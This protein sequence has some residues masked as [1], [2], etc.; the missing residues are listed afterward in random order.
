[1]LAH[2]PY[3][4]LLL[5]EE[6]KCF[7]KVRW[8]GNVPVS[9]SASAFVLDIL[10]TLDHPMK[11]STST[12][13]T[14]L[15]T[16]SSHSPFHAFQKMPE[17]DC[18]SHTKSIK[19]Y[20][21]DDCEVHDIHKTWKK[22]RSCNNK[23]ELRQNFANRSEAL[24]SALR[25]RYSAL[26]GIDMIPALLQ[27][28]FSS[29]GKN[30]EWFEQNYEHCDRD[31]HLGFTGRVSGVVD[32]LDDTQLHE[33]LTRSNKHGGMSLQLQ[34]ERLLKRVLN[35]PIPPKHAPE[36]YNLEQGIRHV[37]FGS[38]QQPLLDAAMISLLTTKNKLT[39]EELD[40]FMGMKRPGQHCRLLFT[41][42]AKQGTS[43]GVA[44]ENELKTIFAG[45][46]EGS[47]MLGKLVE[48]AVQVDT[49]ECVRVNALLALLPQLSL[50]SPAQAKWF[51]YA[52]M[53]FENQYHENLERND[54]TYLSAQLPTVIV[55]ALISLFHEGD[56]IDNNDMPGNNVRIAAAIRLGDAAQECSDSRVLVL[57]AFNRALTT[58]SEKF[59]T[60]IAAFEENWRLLF[61]EYMLRTE[62][63]T[64]LDVICDMQADGCIKEVRRM[65]QRTQGGRVV[66][67]SF[68]RFSSPEKL[69]VMDF[70]M[71]MGVK[72]ARKKDQRAS[73]G[74]M[75]I[76]LESNN[77]EEFAN[78]MKQLSNE[79][80]NE[81]SMEQ[82]QA[83]LQHMQNVK[84]QAER[85]K[86][87]NKGSVVKSRSI[88]CAACGLVDS[89]DN[90]RRC[91]QCKSVSYC[92]K[93][94]Q[95][96]HWRKHKPFCVTTAK[97]GRGP[98]KVKEKV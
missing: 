81:G 94:C 60:S 31:E 75:N 96:Q 65:Y 3:N 11:S 59:E 43:A 16:M 34:R 76:R 7:Q 35:C 70:L 93:E 23:S 4:P 39:T 66:N 72:R 90:M 50:L 92:G 78:M 71:A 86:K 15:A 49:E 68:S 98:V 13:P 83:Q 54:C 56:F 8:A 47:A 17:Y 97:K 38:S 33:I 25:E 58:I 79:G 85:M 27:M 18:K 12:L 42:L 40:S 2:D 69:G 28:S 51:V 88:S 1:M 41:C 95:R 32:E 73:M 61:E 89:G 91:S 46:E 53:H 29:V 37:S 36:L 9:K 87:E 67:H 10:K 5:M 26:Q 64:F 24:Y 6:L 57:A 45:N 77:P 52:V 19:N 48:R 14:M 84:R 63:A 22:W 80:S 62:V 74:N 30:S 82:W 21:G 55:E 44:A 20:C